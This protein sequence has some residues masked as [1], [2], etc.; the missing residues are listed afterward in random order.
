MRKRSVSVRIAAVTLLGVLWAAVR[1]RRRRRSRAPS[2][3]LPPPP[4][5]EVVRVREVER[6][7]G[8][9]GH[10]LQPERLLLR[11]HH[12]ALLRDDAAHDHVGV[13][14]QLEVRGAASP[15]C[16][17]SPFAKTCKNN[18]APIVFAVFPKD[19]NLGVLKSTT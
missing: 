19:I 5:E 11:L 3:R 10:E 16:R 2:L 6:V 14:R 13:E 17:T 8:R 7:V 1:R 18:I 4:S 15:S 12:A 9:D